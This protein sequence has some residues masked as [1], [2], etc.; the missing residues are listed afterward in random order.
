MSPRVFYRLDAPR[1]VGFAPGGPAG[2]WRSPCSPSASGRTS[3]PTPAAWARA[4]SP[5]ALRGSGPRA[6]TRR[7]T[8]SSIPQTRRG[9]S[10]AHVASV[11]R[12]AGATAT[13]ISARPV[14]AATGARGGGIRG[15]GSCSHA[16]VRHAG[17]ALPAADH[18]PR[19]LARGGLGPL[20]R[21]P[22]AACRRAADPH[23]Q[24]A[25]AGHRC[26]RA[27]AA[28]WRNRR[29]APAAKKPAPASRR[30]ETPP[31]HCS[32]RWARCPP[33][34]AP[35]W[36]RWASRRRGRSAS[37][38]SSSRSTTACGERRGASCWR[39]AACWRRPRRIRRPRF[40]RAS[41]PR[42]SRRPSPRSAP[43]TAG[44]WRCARRGRSSRS[45]ASGSTACSLPARPSRW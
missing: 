27:T 36:K 21:V 13:L 3:P 19:R 5:A 39:E 20:G 28:C 15:P 29:W 33:T 40:A 35:N 41:P 12:S 38:A 23:H 1:P 4:R 16:H 22:R 9:V 2:C 24:P 14:G 18:Q 32:G 34:V 43:S 7:C 45:R 26:W 25:A 31:R 8:N 44:S 42:C 37:A 6:T 11:L 30:W 10:L 17:A